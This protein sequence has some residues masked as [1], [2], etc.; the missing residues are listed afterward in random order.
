MGAHCQDIRGRLLELARLG[1]AREEPAAEL[2]EHLGVCAP[3][4]VWAER[5]E[6][7]RR[8]CSV[9]PRL[10]A[11]FELDGRVFAALEAGPRPHRA[12]QSLTDLPEVS[13]PSELSGRV[14]RALSGDAG[15]LSP[16]RAPTVLARLVSEELADP[17]RATIRRQVSALPRLSAPA[18][19]DRRV[20]REITRPAPRSRGG[21]RSALAAALLCA[22]LFVARG[23]WTGAP[24]PEPAQ[25]SF[26]LVRTSDP[27]ALSP[28]A[29]SFSPALLSSASRRPSGP[30]GEEEL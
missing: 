24:E 8:H 16:S 17:A 11:P 30:D 6:R 12:P 15:G 7:L 22:A 21:R 18:A 20:A 10:Q 28:L 9:L 3:C 27:D 26:E 5:A 29:R 19:L 14:A 1:L 13:A 4:R 23:L 2:T 25:L